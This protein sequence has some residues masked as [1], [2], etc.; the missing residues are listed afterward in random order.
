MQA[1]SLNESK[2]STRGGPRS[3]RNGRGTG[4]VNG[5]AERADAAS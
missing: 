5:G 3:A 1:D 4:K 2:L